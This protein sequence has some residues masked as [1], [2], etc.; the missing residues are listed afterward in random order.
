MSWPDSTVIAP[1]TAYHRASY[2]E[3]YSRYMKS[4]MA[5]IRGIAMIHFQ[6]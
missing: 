5:P 2:A 1:V 3:R 4:L 6:Q